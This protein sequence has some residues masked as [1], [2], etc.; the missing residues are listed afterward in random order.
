MNASQFPRRATPRA[1]GTA[2]T[3][4]WEPARSYDYPKIGGL[5]GRLLHG[6]ERFQYVRHGLPR[7]ASVRLRSHENVSRLPATMLTPCLVGSPRI[8]RILDARRLRRF[9]IAAC[10]RSELVRRV[11]GQPNPPPIGLSLPCRICLSATPTFTHSVHRPPRP[12]RYS[13]RQVPQ[14]GRE[15]ASVTSPTA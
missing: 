14:S 11:P 1:H 5:A 15:P 7:H 4:S 8:S 12:S 6:N 9:D 10:R 13:L 2:M 3:S